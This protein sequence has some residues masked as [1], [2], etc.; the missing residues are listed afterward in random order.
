MAPQ[1]NCLKKGGLCCEV[2]EGYKALHCTEES[3]CRQYVILAMT[4][5]EWSLRNPIHMHGLIVTNTQS[6][7]PRC[8]GHAGTLAMTLRPRL[9]PSRDRAGPCSCGNMLQKRWTNGWREWK[10]AIQS[11]G[12]KGIAAEDSE[13]VSRQRITRRCRR[14]GGSEEEDVWKIEQE[15]RDKRDLRKMNIR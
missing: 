8:R 2:Q 10:V 13:L 9:K 6:H 14:G 15:D 4:L 12:W 1:E 3:R 11:Q 5:A 7:T